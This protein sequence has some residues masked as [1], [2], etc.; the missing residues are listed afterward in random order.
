MAL[1]AGCD[2]SLRDEYRPGLKK[3]YHKGL[4]TEHD[5]NVAV[6]RVL[7]LRARL[8][9]DKGTDQGNPYKNTPYSVVE[10]ERHQQL[11]LEA[12][13]KSMILLKNEGGIAAETGCVKEN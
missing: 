7:D 12:A 2:M 8:G 5:L 10:C 9:L 3:A 6:A 1:R 4:I 13:E 11:A